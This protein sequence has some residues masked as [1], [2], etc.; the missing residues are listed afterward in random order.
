MNIII[1]S[2]SIETYREK[3][4]VLEL[5]TIRILPENKEITAYCVV[6][7]IPIMELP[8][9]DSKKRLH[10]SLMENYR[11]RDWNFC[12]QALEQLYGSWNKEV[13]SFYNDLRTRINFYMQQDPGA[14]WDGVVEK[15]S[16]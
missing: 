15:H 6:E 14:Q 13:D 16:S 3:Y 7:V 12:S 9:T 2:G 5:D 8:L 1:D 4:T 10:A 11:K